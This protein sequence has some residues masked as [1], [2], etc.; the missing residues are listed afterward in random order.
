MLSWS[1]TPPKTT[2]DFGYR[3]VR[4]PAY[5]ALHGIIL[6]DD[7][8]GTFTHYAKG[9]TMPCPQKECEHCNEGKPY[10]WHAYVPV[11]CLPG[12]EKVLLEITALA[13]EQLKEYR[14]RFCSLRGLE[15]LVLRPSKRPNGRITIQAKASGIPESELPKPPIVE[16]ILLHIWGLDDAALGDNGRQRGI[17]S[18]LV[19]DASILDVVLNPSAMP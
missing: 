13:A 12:K 4:T 15:I 19:K 14:S 1:T 7:L 17:P 18:R 9:R 8:L 2:S 6:A 3:L 5:K 10:R 11:L 16:R